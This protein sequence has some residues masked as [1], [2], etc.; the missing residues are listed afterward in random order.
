M[1]H[2]AHTNATSTAEI[3]MKNFI[4]C[5]GLFFGYTFE[6]LHGLTGEDI[7][8]FVFKFLSIISISFVIIINWPK[9]KET[10]IKGYKKRKYD[11]RR[12]KKKGN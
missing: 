5:I 4:S 12:K 3:G 9:V 8:N 11:F 1:E 10:I 7:Y 2:I 6:A